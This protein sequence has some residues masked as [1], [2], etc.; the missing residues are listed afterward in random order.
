MSSPESVL[1]ARPADEDAALDTT[2]RP[3]SL[4]EYVGQES[5]RANLQVAI[6]AAKGRGESLDHLLLYGPPGLGK[7]SLAHIVAR[8]LDVNIRTTAGP[9][10]ERPGANPRTG[11]GGFVP[12]GS[13]ADDRFSRGARRYRREPQDF[14]ARARK[15]Q[16]GAKREKPVGA[17]R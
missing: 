16:A 10:I 4:A 3:P 13:G 12:S 2:L 15:L 6:D 17:N 14:L 5:V 7:T 9:V 1:S 11:P 8:E